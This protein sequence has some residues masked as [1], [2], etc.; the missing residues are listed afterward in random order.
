MEVKYI[1]FSDEVTTAG[2]SALIS[3]TVAYII[4][5]RNNRRA[6]KA[7][8]D[9]RYNEIIKMSYD[10]TDLEGTATPSNWEHH[11]KY[12]EGIYTRYHQYCKLLFK[13]LEDYSRYY[14]FNIKKIEESID[15]EEWVNIHKY[16]WDKPYYVH[17]RPK[18]Y[19]KKFINMVDS[20]IEKQTKRKN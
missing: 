4:S 3:G 7:S 17:E 2:I 18:R 15:I 5:K 13:F 14:N 8:L 20:L 19:S 6:D 11:R 1:F 16:W 9:N 12:D 10:N